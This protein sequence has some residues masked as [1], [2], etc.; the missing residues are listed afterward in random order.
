MAAIILG[1]NFVVRAQ[2]SSGQFSS[3][4]FS[5][6][7]LSRGQFSSGQLSS[8]QLFRG[9]NLCVNYSEAIIQGGAIVPEPLKNYFR[10]FAIKY[11]YHNCVR[12][13]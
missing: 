1:G 6:R 9:N 5:G 4:Q 13:S 2:F 12:A 10:K 11:S 3:G 7:Q 8:V